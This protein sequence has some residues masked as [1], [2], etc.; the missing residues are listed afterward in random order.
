[1][2]DSG[3]IRGNLTNS[4]SDDAELSTKRYGQQFSSSFHH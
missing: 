1:M 4:L 3:Q 2:S